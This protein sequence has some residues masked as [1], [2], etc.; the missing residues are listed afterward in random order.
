MLALDPKETLSAAVVRRQCLIASALPSVQPAP[1]AELVLAADQCIITPAGRIEDTAR[2]RAAGDE[3]RTVIAGY[4]R[5][6]DWGRDTMISLAGLTLTTGRHQ[7]AAWIPRTFGHYIRDGLI[8]NLFPEGERDGLYHTADT[9]LRFF[10]ALPGQDRKDDEMTPR[11]VLHKGGD[12]T[13][14]GAAYEIGRYEQLLTLPGP[15]DASK[16]KIDR[17]GSTLTITLPKAEHAGTTPGQG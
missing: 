10:H 12:K 11:T 3:V 16:M 14:A 9:T 5:F 15:V 8:P 7:E 17:S 6:T 2:A 13:A 1:A 4:H